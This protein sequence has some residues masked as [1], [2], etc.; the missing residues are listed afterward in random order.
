MMMIARIEPQINF[1][2]C[3]E[4][5]IRLT[6]TPMLIKEKVIGKRAKQPNVV[7]GKCARNRR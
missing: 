4:C 6:G 1:D 2:Y 3:S 7:C 5:G